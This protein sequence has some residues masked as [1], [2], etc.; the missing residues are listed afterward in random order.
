MKYNGN[1]PWGIFLDARKNVIL[2]MKHKMKKTDK[3]IA[4]DLS[5]DEEQVFSIREYAEKN[6]NR[7]F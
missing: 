5:M 2:W 1:H 4:E 3:Q 7:L 6:E